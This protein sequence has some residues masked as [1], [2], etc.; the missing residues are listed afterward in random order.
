MYT[1]QM[2]TMFL[3]LIQLQKTRQNIVRMTTQ[4]IESTGTADYNGASNH[5][6]I[7]EIVG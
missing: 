2:V 1:N 7:Q 5:N 3:Q 4:G 6:V